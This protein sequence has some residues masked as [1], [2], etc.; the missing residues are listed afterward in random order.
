MHPT[1]LPQHTDQKK[2]W[3]QDMRHNPDQSTGYR[4]ERAE[5][6]TTAVP[7]FYSHPGHNNKATLRA[8]KQTSLPQQMLPGKEGVKLNK[9][10]TS[11]AN[12]GQS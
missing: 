11:L 8:L 5:A 12:V 10:L 9:P 2:L 3:E 7:D 6:W 4:G 1:H